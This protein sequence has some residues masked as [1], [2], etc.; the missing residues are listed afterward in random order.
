MTLYPSDSPNIS[1]TLPDLMKSYSS[2]LT[3]TQ[4]WGD[5]RLEMC[6]FIIVW[7][8]CHTYSLLSASEMFL[9]Y[10]E[11]LNADTHCFSQFKNGKLK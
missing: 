4:I 9:F 6:T 7:V 5:F 1:S 3:K 11:F 10:L 8:T 2:K